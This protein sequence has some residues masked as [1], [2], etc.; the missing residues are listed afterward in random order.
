[1]KEYLVYH[2]G[3]WAT[4][5]D[6][7]IVSF[8]SDG[9]TIEIRGSKKDVAEWANVLRSSTV[10]ASSMKN[11]NVTFGRWL[12]KNTYSAWTWFFEEDYDE[13]K[14]LFEAVKGETVSIKIDPN[15]GL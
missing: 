12:N 4:A 8:I 15:K 1:M 9:D 10:L 7:G 2:G 3:N 14:D 5:D 11:G 13:Y 6:P